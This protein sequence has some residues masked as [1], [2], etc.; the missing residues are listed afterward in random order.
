[1]GWHTLA[2]LTEKA[3]AMQAAG[4]DYISTLC[5]KQTDKQA[6]TNKQEWKWI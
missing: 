4:L 5:L 2:I 3:K 6:N 1:M